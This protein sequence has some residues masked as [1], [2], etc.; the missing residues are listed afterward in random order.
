MHNHERQYTHL[1]TTSD[2]LIYQHTTLWKMLIQPKCPILQVRDLSPERSS[3]SHY[4]CLFLL[5]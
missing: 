5:T 4:H 3:K 1:L 2:H